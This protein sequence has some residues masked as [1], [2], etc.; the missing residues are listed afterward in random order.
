MA[1]CSMQRFKID[2]KNRVENCLILSNVRAL[3]VVNAI[4]H[5]LIDDR[6]KWQNEQMDGIRTNF[7]VYTRIK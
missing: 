2:S 1:D 4:V 7:P 5:Q 6:N 3:I